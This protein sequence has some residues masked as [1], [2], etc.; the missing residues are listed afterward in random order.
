[1]IALKSLSLAAAILASSIATI[2]AAAQTLSQ[3]DAI[4][5]VGIMTTAGLAALNLYQKVRETK[6]TQDAEDLKLSASS[7]R[8]KAAQLEGQLKLVKA[9]ARRWHKMYQSAKGDD[10]GCE[11]RPLTG[12]A[13]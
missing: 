13:P 2:V 12:Q 9:E 1:M 10:P 7:D 3:Q 4:A 8:A 6:R 5:W 11:E